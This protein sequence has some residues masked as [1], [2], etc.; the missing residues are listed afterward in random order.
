MEKSDG[1][2]SQPSHCRDD[3]PTPLHSSESFQLHPF[4]Q[5]VPILWFAHALHLFESSIA[6]INAAND[7]TEEAA[8]T[9]M[10]F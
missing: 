2:F 9:A 6:T 10:L 7:E 4:L 3:S 8:P 5:Q 1:W